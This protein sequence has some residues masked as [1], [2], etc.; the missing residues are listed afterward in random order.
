MVNVSQLKKVTTILF[1]K[2]KSLLS[3]FFLE[4]EGGNQRQ[5]YPCQGVSN[6][7]HS[8]ENLTIYRLRFDSINIYIQVLTLL[9]TSL[10][11]LSLQVKVLQKFLKVNHWYS[12]LKIMDLTLEEKICFIHL[13]Y[14]SLSYLF[15]LCFFG[16]GLLV[17][18]SMVAEEEWGSL[19]F[20]P[21]K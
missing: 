15:T 18:P 8:P 19:L 14:T 2:W 16:L 3:H 12:L 6:E 10:R 4:R 17:V 13:P 7:T 21:I 20:Q 5:N 11:S 1:Q 9:N